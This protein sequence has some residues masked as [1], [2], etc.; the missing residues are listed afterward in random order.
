VKVVGNFFQLH[1]TKSMDLEPAL[2]FFRS[3]FAVELWTYL[4][5]KSWSGIGFSDLELPGLIISIQSKIRA[6]AIIC[7]CLKLGISDMNDLT[8]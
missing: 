4:V 8:I 5:G 6:E 7:H 1:S 2:P 3:R